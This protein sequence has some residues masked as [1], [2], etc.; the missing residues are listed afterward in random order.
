MEV[1]DMHTMRKAMEL[2][3]EAAQSRQ[4][5]GHLLM[6]ASSEDEEDEAHKFV[7]RARRA[8]EEAEKLARQARGED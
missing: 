3:T 6:C 1:I 4:W 7:E 8:E 5:A 2:R